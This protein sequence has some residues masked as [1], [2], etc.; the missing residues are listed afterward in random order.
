[1]A[2]RAPRRTDREKFEDFFFD[3]DVVEQARLID[4]LKSLHRIKQ[5]RSRSMM[6]AGWNLRGQRNDHH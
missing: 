5:S 3:Q 6:P 2:K 4:H 1:M